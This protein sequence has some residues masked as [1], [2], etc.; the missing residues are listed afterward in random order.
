MARLSFKEFLKLFEGSITPGNVHLV[1]QHASKDI[2]ALT[3]TEEFKRLSKANAET[4]NNI[5]A[6]WEEDIKNPNRDSLANK[7]IAKAKEKLPSIAHDDLN[8]LNLLHKTAFSGKPA[9]RTISSN[10]ADAP[11]R[12]RQD[13]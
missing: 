6:A 3:N 9:G 10:Y 12:S 11:T 4:A 8:G 5:K 1:A 13:R 2:S 7:V